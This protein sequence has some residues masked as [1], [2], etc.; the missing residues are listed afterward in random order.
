LDQLSA[1]L[2]PAVQDIKPMSPG[3]GSG[4]YSTLAS[5]LVVFVLYLLFTV[6][7]V[8]SLEKI[9]IPWQNFKEQLPTTLINNSGSISVLKND[10]ITLSGSYQGLRPENV[11]IVIEDSTQ[12]TK[13]DQKNDQNR[14]L[15]SLNSNSQF[16]YELNHVRNSFKYYFIG[17]LNHPRFRD[18]VAT[19]V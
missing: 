15:L 1:K 14:L 18:L 11:Y 17:D 10:P 12:S 13:S 6:Q 9:F 19:S 2:A 4:L 16:N 7:I 3:F 8:V 5:I